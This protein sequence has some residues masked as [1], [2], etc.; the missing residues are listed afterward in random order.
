MSI[1]HE[2]LKKVQ[3]N[4][5][6]QPPAA[7]EQITGQPPAEPAA[8]KQQAE[9]KA[10]QPPQKTKTPFPLLITL[11]FIST[12]I[13]ALWFIVPPTMRHIS[14]LLNH[15]RNTIKTYSIVPA[16]KKPDQ[17]PARIMI[18]SVPP[19]FNVQG[20]MTNNG[21]TV[22]LIN[23]KIYERG[24]ELGGAKITGIAAEAITISRNGAEETIPVRH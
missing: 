1:I 4:L 23:G 5:Q 10:A 19:V 24:D 21:S 11:V 14:P 2:A 17:P 8:E 20:V 13:A 6:N 3:A 15:L 22:A 16:A 9:D 18:P 12:A 7:P